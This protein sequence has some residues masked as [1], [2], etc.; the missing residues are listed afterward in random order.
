[1]EELRLLKVKYF[2]WSNQD[3]TLEAETATAGLLSSGLS[4]RGGG[5]SLPMTLNPTGAWRG[6]N[7]KVAM[8][9]T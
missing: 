2:S 6:E 1:M 8:L 5:G 9:H 7:M 3:L 4:Y